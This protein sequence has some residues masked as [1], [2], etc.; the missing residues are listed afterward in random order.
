MPIFFD[1]KHISSEEANFGSLHEHIHHD[2][3][4]KNVTEREVGDMHIILV[5]Y[6]GGIVHSIDGRG[7]T[8]MVEHDSL[9]NS[10][11]SRGEAQG[12][13][14]LASGHFDGFAVLFTSFNNIFIAHKLVSFGGQLSLEFFR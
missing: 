6:Q 4:F 14:I 5:D 3:S 10:S 7:D 9:G 11:G 13:K 2:H 8:K 1:G 12:E